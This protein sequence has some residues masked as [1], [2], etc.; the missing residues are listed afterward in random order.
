MLLTH[1]SLLARSVYTI[2]NTDS[3]MTNDTVVVGYP[4]P[5]V[6]GYKN[7][8][9]ATHYR[10]ALDRV[11]AVPGVTAAAFSTFRPGGGAPPREVI[12]RANTPRDAA[13]A[14]GEWA[15]VS[16]G[17]F[18][19]LGIPILRGRDFS[20]TES[21]KSAKV[22]VI[23]AQLERDLFGEGL[24]LGQHIRVSP[25]PEWQD[26]EVV[27]VV[28]DARVFDVRSNTRSIIYTNAI[29][30]GP[31][32]HYK[33]LIARAPE[34]TASDLR[35]AIESFGVEL[36]RRTVTLDYVRSRTILQERL[37]AGLGSA[38]AL[39]A[40]VLIAA[41]IYGLLSYVLSLRRKEIG[42]RLALGAEA[43]QMARGIVS[44]GLVVTALGITVGL[45]GA[46]AS[47]PLLRSVLVGVSPYD[48]LA[49][50]GACLLLILVTMT[51]SLAPALR[52]ARVEPIAELRH[53]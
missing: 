42:I 30:S 34:S 49:I 16:P 36:M 31:A 9:V 6:N 45:A 5:V 25:R 43:G 28:S 32:S 21:E 4:S 1:A 26:V 13:D 23:S 15:Q 12:G 7:L 35:K 53:D 10:Q 37:M 39:L 24:G 22:A 18:E 11:R 14:Q 44:D 27:G 41:G 50:G 51:T 17:F 3:G 8:D 2:T 52:A 48:P 46:L 40:L 29:Q 20:Y 19:V 47:V 33:C 38:F